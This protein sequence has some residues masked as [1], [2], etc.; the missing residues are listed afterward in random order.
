MHPAQAAFIASVFWWT[1]MAVI[2]GLLVWALDE[3]TAES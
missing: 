2:L 3:G 1:A